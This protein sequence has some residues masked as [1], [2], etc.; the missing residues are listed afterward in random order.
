MASA[1]ERPRKRE[2][3]TKQPLKSSSA[4]TQEVSGVQGLLQLV[5][6]AHARSAGR[7]SPQAGPP[8]PW[9]AMDALPSALGGLRQALL[10]VLILRHEHRTAQG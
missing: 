8:P 7:P 9:G 3:R 5:I 6:K 1:F 10:A 4:Q 2:P